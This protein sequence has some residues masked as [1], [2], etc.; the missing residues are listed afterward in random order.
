[1]L[2]RLRL[3]LAR[4]RKLNFRTI[5]DTMGISSASAYIKH[6][7]SLRNACALI[8]YKSSRDCDWIDT[9]HHWAEVLSSH[10]AKTADTLRIDFGLASGVDESGVGL[11]VNGALRVSFLVAR[12]VKKKKPEHTTQWRACRRQMRAGLV[13]VLRLDHGN[14]T[15]QDYL[16][17]PLPRKVAP[18]VTLTDALLP[19]HKAVCVDSL[20]RLI[21]AI[22]A[23][24]KVRAS[25]AS[26]R[27]RPGKP[28]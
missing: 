17:L 23:R 27:R 2:R 13:V 10:V 4:K 26:S 28:R 6:F 1:M 25:A 14:K 8:G 16:L 5:N 19:H 7:R 12:Q 21:R 15:L 9:R 20:D 18:Y 24:L 3:T 22:K 11:T